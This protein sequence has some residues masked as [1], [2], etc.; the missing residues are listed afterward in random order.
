M[1]AVAEELPCFFICENR[2]LFLF[3][4]YLISHCVLF[5]FLSFCIVAALISNASVSISEWISLFGFSQYFYGHLQDLNSDRCISRMAKHPEA[6]TAVRIAAPGGF[7]M[8]LRT[9]E[10]FRH[11]LGPPAPRASLAAAPLRGELGIADVTPGTQ[12]CPRSIVG[13]RKAEAQRTAA[14]QVEGWGSRNPRPFTLSLTKM[15]HGRA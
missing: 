3:F 12:T 14:L 8:T 6:Q 2:P 1:P 13:R 7:R 5:V 11:S 15:T 4:Y 10:T 9:T